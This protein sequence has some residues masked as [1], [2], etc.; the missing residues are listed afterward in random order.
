MSN[1]EVVQNREPIWET[2]LDSLRNRLQSPTPDPRHRLAVRPPLPDP[3]HPHNRNTHGATCQFKFSTDHCSALRVGCRGIRTS[4]HTQSSS[5]A[6][7]QRIQGVYVRR[8]GLLAYVVA[9]RQKDDT[10]CNVKSDHRLNPK[11][12]F[13][14]SD[15]IHGVLQTDVKAK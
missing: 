10:R 4:V 6:Q 13:D 11:G 2:S 7:Y 14:I 3:W 9:L 1:S 5:V 8:N 12:L 15:E